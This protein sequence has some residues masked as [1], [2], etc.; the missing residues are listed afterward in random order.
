MTVNSLHHPFFPA[1]SMTENYGSVANIYPMDLLLRALALRIEKLYYTFHYQVNNKCTKL[2]PKNN[3]VASSANQK[4]SDEIQRRN[5][6]LCPCIPRP[7]IGIPP[8]YTPQS[9]L[10]YYGRPMS[11]PFHHFAESNRC[12]NGHLYEPSKYRVS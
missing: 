8:D 10:P 2:P 11:N 5:G 4:L 12:H 6:E 7:I 1:T 9:F 3:K